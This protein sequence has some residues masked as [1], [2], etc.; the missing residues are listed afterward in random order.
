MITDD[1]LLTA[2]K[3]NLNTIQALTHTIKQ[4]EEKVSNQVKLLPRYEKLLAVPGIGPSYVVTMK[5]ETGDVNRFPGGGEDASYCRL[6]KS[7]KISNNKSKRKNGNQYLSW[8]YVGVAEK[9]K[10]YSTLAKAYFERRK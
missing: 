1:N 5:L 2:A 10:R 4:L 8:V 6:V 9:A 3:A 7:A